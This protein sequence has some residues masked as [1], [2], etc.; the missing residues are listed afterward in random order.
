MVAEAAGLFV[1]GAIIGLIIAVMIRGAILLMSANIMSIPNSTFG[2][3]CG[4]SILGVIVSIILSLLG[5]VG[6]VAG[7]FVSALIMMGIFNTTYGKALGAT[8]ICEAIIWIAIIVGCLMFG[9][10]IAS[11]LAVL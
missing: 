9:V 6:W 1:I 11:I 5:P 3:A 4:A 7:F 8:L 2:K 10:G